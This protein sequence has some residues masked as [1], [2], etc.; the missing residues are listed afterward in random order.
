MGLSFG[1]IDLGS[2]LASYSSGT[3][4]P[5]TGF[6]V[7]GSDVSNSYQPSAGS[8]DRGSGTFGF[9]CRNGKDLLQQCQGSGFTGLSLSPT[10]ITTSC[11]HG[12]SVDSGSSCTVS[13]MLNTAGLTYTWAQSGATSPYIS[14]KTSGATT[15]F[16]YNGGG[17]FPGA[18]LA[19]YKCTI[20]DGTNSVIVTG[21]TVTFS[22]TS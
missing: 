10:I 18:A 6:V 15:S 13:G 7:G 9:K 4:I 2:F 20:S 11:A 3:K 22:F 1:N 12:A 19:G 16:H 21:L 8:W 17:S 14:A 5:T